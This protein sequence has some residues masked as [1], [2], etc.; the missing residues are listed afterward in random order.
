MNKFS[1]KYGRMYRLKVGLHEV[2]IL[3]SLDVIKATLLKK[4]G[5][6][7]EKVANSQMS[8]LDCKGK[9]IAYTKGEQWRIQRNF[10][11]RIMR[12]VGWGRR[13]YEVNI[14]REIDRLIGRVDTSANT[15]VPFNITTLLNDMVTRILC[16]F[17][18]GQRSLN[19]GDT[20]QLCELM[21]AFNDDTNIAALLT[22]LPP[23]QYLPVKRFKSVLTGV[24]KIRDLILEQVE[25]KMADTN[26]SKEESYDPDF[27][28]WNS[29]RKSYVDAFL[30][31]MTRDKSQTEN[32]STMTEICFTKE[33][34]VLAIIDM[35][36]GNETVNSALS[37]TFLVLS[38]RL[39]IQRTIWTKLDNQLGKGPSSKTPTLQDRQQLD[40]VEAVVLEALRTRPTSPLGK[41]WKCQADTSIEGYDIP[42]G[43]IVI[44]NYWSVLG[45]SDIWNNPHEFHPERFLDDNGKLGKIPKEFTSFGVGPRSCPGEQLAKADMFLVISRLCQR[46]EFKIARCDHSSIGEMKGLSACPKYEVFVVRR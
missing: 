5:L 41:T 46:Y 43:S 40:Y 39:D 30:A 27:T 42:K 32:A 21:N 11:T 24:L 26:V 19:D 45:G 12:D 35:F 29:M 9:G 22:L 13:D 7:N 36:F 4:A 14:Q 38:T 44:P 28:N 18:F 17:I 15:G 2:I 16:V 37:W 31:E 6:F 34:L 10:F 20:E 8:V 1:K 3:N 25:K 23:L 33:S